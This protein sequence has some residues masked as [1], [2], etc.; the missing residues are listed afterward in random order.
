MKDRPTFRKAVLPNFY[1]GVELYPMH[2][3]DEMYLY[4]HSVARALLG[5]SQ[6]ASRRWSAKP[7]PQASSI[8][9]EQSQRT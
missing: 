2:Y 8:E 7:E 3:T 4:G 5:P 6:P 1:T 9:P